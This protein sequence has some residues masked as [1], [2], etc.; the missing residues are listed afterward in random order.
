VLR[1]V[2]RILVLSLLVSQLPFLYADPSEDISISRDAWTDE[3]LNTSQ[4]A[5]YVNTGHF[6]LAEC[7]NLVKSPAYNLLLVPVFSV[8]GTTRFN[9]R[10]F[11]LLFSLL[12]VWLC[13]ELIPPL[14]PVLA[15]LLPIAWL[16]WYLLQYLHFS[17]VEMPASVSIILLL[18]FTSRLFVRTSPAALIKYTMFSVATVWWIVSLK[19]QFMYLF[20]VPVL[21]VVLLMFRTSIRF[22]DKVWV[23][24]TAFGAFVLGVV[25]Y[26][27]AW[28]SRV[29]PVMDMVLDNQAGGRFPDISGVVVHLRQNLDRMFL[30][31]H[32]RIF[33]YAFLLSVPAGVY[34]FYRGRDSVRKALFIAACLWVLAEL[35]KPFI[36]FVPSRYLVSTWLS[37]AFLI[38]LVCTE[39]FFYLREQRQSGKRLLVYPAYVV[40]LTGMF[41]IYFQG[42]EWL[43]A[44]EG[45]TYRLNNMHTYFKARVRPGSVILGAWAPSVAMDCGAVTLPVWKGFLSGAD[46][47]FR[48]KPVAIVAECDEADSEGFWIS[49]G[50][51][52]S[53]IADS[54]YRFSA[55]RYELAV[56]WISP[57]HPLE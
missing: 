46:T 57:H 42:M 38:S 22:S 20:L 17:M 33:T 6:G 4:A 34:F 11:V 47:T 24:G 30:S 55:G 7:D 51:N 31:S 50:I 45:R 8:A 18:W 12:I 26:Y 52:P 1:Y 49:K 10:V 53:A 5:N 39:A 16:Q 41:L 35:H 56:Y 40:L 14:L 44:V 25:V 27:A 23:V 15:V 29:Q 21:A 54:M 2:F 9:A 13:G 32:T 43:R 48:N 36:M 3:G 19:L 28:Y 37:M